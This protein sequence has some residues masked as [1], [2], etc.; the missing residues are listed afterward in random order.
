MS[1][2]SKRLRKRCQLLELRLLELELKERLEE[3]ER[4]PTILGFSIIGEKYGKD[5]P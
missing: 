5:Q 3:M 1:K 2:K 4:K